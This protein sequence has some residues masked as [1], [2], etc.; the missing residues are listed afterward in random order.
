MKKKVLVPFGIVLLLLIAYFV[1]S[2]FLRNTS[3]VIDDY[4]VSADGTEITLRAAAASSVGYLRD[5]AVHQQQGGKLYLDC[6]GAFGGVNGKL[7]AKNSFTVPLERDTA[8]IAV[9][10]GSGC[11]QEVLKKTEDGTWQRVN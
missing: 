9:Y 7:G 3:A 6:Y 2:G 10:R 11:Y 8:V 1:G 4:A 5:V